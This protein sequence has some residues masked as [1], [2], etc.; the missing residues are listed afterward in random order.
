VPLL[1]G[2]VEFGSFTRWPRLGNPPPVVWRD[3]ATQSTQ[4]R[5]GLKNPGARAA[6]VFL[7]D[8][9]LPK[10]W[11][12]SLAPTPGVDDPEQQRREVCESV[13]FFSS[14]GLKPAWVTVN[15]SCPNTEA[16][17]HGTQ[18]EGLARTVCAGVRAVLGD[19]IPLWVKIGPDLGEAQVTALARTFDAVGVRAVVATNTLAAPAPSGGVTAGLAGGRL[20]AHSLAV[21]R[22]LAAV[23]R[24]DGLQFDIVGCGGGLDGRAVSA[25]TQA[26]ARAVQVWSALVFRGPLAPAL[27][28]AEYAQV[29]KDAGEN[30]SQA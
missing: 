26:G 6:A 30:D 29:R 12:V 13:E 11:G 20:F 28:G 17:P 8:K 2:A 4:N 10:V 18:S 5:I 24:A 3:V 1:C 9:P 22:Q 7:R 21:V 14:A 15:L 25:Y 19:N 27:I 23:K 16:D